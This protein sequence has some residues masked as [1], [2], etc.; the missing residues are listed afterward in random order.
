MHQEE[1]LTSFDCAGLCSTYTSLSPGV[2]KFI[3]VY[4]IG[5]NLQQARDEAISHS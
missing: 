5:S 3:K 4:Q 2:Q 1:L